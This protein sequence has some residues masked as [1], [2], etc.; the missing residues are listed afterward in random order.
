MLGCNQGHLRKKVLHSYWLSVI[1]R[2][3]EM[4]RGR[5]A[6]AQIEDESYYRFGVSFGLVGRTELYVRPWTENRYR[7]GREDPCR[8]C[9]A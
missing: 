6:G 2:E 8:E 4:D 1:A 3:R 9:S 7:L 5:G